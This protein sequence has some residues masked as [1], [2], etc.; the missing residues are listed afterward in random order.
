MGLEIVELIMRVEEE[1]EI[2]IEDEEA[3]YIS[4]VG[5]LHLCILTKLG[6]AGASGCQSSATFYQMRRALMEIADVSRAA[7]RPDTPTAPLLPEPNRRAQWK[8]LSELTGATLPPL[9]RPR[10]LAKSIGMGGA[11][12]GV[13]SLACVFVS[14][15]LAASSALTGAVAYV[16]AR[17]W[18]DRYATLLPAQC[19]TVGDLSHAVIK[20]NYGINLERGPKRSEA[21]IWEKLR[22][23]MVDELDIEP[24]EI[25][26]DAQFVRDLRLG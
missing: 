23:I 7:I 4:T 17:K 13:S 16:G 5:E 18:S 6:L 11:L 25:T 2:A 3:S 14:P 9:E 12:I 1:F 15:A 19:A 26:K 22:E 8:T 24:D 20:L 10:V 21:E